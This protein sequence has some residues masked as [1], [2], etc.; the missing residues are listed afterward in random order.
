LEYLG[1]WEYK[2][3]VNLAEKDGRVLT[4]FIWLMIMTGGMLF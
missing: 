1:R 3:K 4:S 2:I